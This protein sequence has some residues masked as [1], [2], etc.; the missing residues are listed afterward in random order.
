MVFVL[1]GVS[2]SEGCQHHQWQNSSS[3]QRR[4]TPICFHR[5]D[6]KMSVRV[7]REVLLWL[8]YRHHGTPFPRT[9][10]KFS[11]LSIFFL[12]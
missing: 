11:K 8:I 9:T 10:V 12:V 5:N 2:V 1:V 7:K 3:L 4:K 6:K